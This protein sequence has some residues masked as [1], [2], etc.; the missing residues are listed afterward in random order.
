MGIK[1]QGG[2]FGR[3]PTFNDVTVE[4][5]LTS[6]GTITGGSFASSGNMTFGDSDKA[7]FGA[8][9]DLEIYH[10]GNHSWIRDNGTG[11]LFIRGSD[12]VL[13]DASG[14]GFIACTDI[15]NA[16]IVQLKYSDVTKLTTSATG[17]DIS[18]NVKVTSGNGIDF[19]ATAGTGTSELFDDYEEGTW[20]PEFADAASGGNVSPSQAA[21]VGT[22]T[23]IGNLVVCRFKVLNIDTTGMTSGNDFFIRGFPFLSEGTTY[24]DNVGTVALARITFTDAVAL[25]L[26]RNETYARLVEY[27]SGA[28][29][30][31]ITVGEVTTNLAD[32][33]A[34]ICYTAA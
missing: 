27:A 2:V 31:Y 4:G 19:S 22:Y 29:A 30:D 20:T 15:G 14:Y 23:K 8:G 18:G 7:I 17:V 11:N 16:G 26:P 3:N 10:D 24:N 33:T 25:E 13:T 1:Q 34:T 12:L 9:S 21:L 32:I 28:D 6:D 5:T